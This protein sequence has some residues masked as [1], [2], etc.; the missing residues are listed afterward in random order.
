MWFLKPQN[1]HEKDY[2]MR[3]RGFVIPFGTSS[4]FKQQHYA[5]T[6]TS[7]LCGP[8]IV[9]NQYTSAGWRDT[10]KW[11]VPQQKADKL[12]WKEQQ[13]CQ[14]AKAIANVSY[15]WSNTTL[16]CIKLNLMEIF[17]RWNAICIKA[18]QYIEM[19]ERCMRWQRMRWQC[20]TDLF[21]EQYTVSWHISL[22]LQVIAHRYKITLSNYNTTPFSSLNWYHP[23]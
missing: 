9:D 20:Q 5:G 7:V 19:L 21:Q 23:V 14:E 13:R 6:H 16:K 22:S 4:S 18:T 2:Y 10:S 15:V 17:Q 1:S 8:I 12:R 11:I 3:F